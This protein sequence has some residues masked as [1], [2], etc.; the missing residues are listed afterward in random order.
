[1]KGEAMTGKS[2]ECLVI[3]LNKACN[4]KCDYCFINKKQ[5]T[6]KIHSEL[7]DLAS[8]GYYVSRVNELFDDDEKKNIRI[9]DI[10]GGEPTVN[11]NEIKKLFG[12]LSAA[13]KNIDTLKF[14][15]NF[16][17]PNAAHIVLEIYNE[18]VALN[19]ENGHNKPFSIDIQISI[20]GPSDITD[21]NR[22]DNVA[23]SVLKNIKILCD[24]LANHYNHQACRLKLHTHCVFDTDTVNA[25]S[26]VDGIKDFFDY[27]YEMYSYVEKFNLTG[28]KI[29]TIPGICM[30]FPTPETS[31]T[32][33][34]AA[35][36]Y[37]SL[38]EFYANGNKYDYSTDFWDRLLTNMPGESLFNFPISGRNHLP[39]RKERKM[40]LD[41]VERLITTH[42]IT[43]QPE[44]RT[45]CGQ[46]F[47]SILLAPDNEY[48]LCQNCFFDRYDAYVDVFAADGNSNTR[49][50]S[51]QN[52]D[53]KKNTKSWIWRTDEEFL[54]FRNVVTTAYDN[55]SAH[56]G[57]YGPELVARTMIRT[58][59]RAGVIDKKYEDP[60]ECSYAARYTDI[61]INCMSLL[62]SLTG[63]IHVPAMYYLPLYL[64]GA[65]DWID[66]IMLLRIEKERKWL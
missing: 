40:F 19:H 36:M 42:T 4:L 18:L 31:E 59:A 51:N 26:T 64:N 53:Y 2:I 52:A 23:E 39:S 47:G 1:M 3:M 34:L 56:G 66:K 35:K 32:G 21:R 48:A 8:N 44:S 5:G 30:M 12:D 7:V 54:R 9:L 16:A 62:L 14:S 25:L 45:Y 24:E 50:I 17:L 63:S 49:F 38:Y 46:A 57:Y 29:E 65:M 11:P 10:W 28:A 22:G 43:A 60:K 55:I 33:K 37:K 6:E 61:N 41:D 20:D 58:M 15:T 13:C 27:F